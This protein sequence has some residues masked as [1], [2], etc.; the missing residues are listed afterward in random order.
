MSN[1]VLI[2]MP[3]PIHTPRLT[4][5]SKEFGD[6]AIT[7]AA[8]AETWE[9]LNRWMRWADNKNAFTP[10]LMEIRN[11]H[12][13]AAF[14]LRESIELIGL[15]TQTGKAVVWCGFHDIDWEARQCD[16]GYWVRKSAQRQGFAT[17]TA[18]AMLRYAFGALGMRRVGLT[19]SSGN[20]PTR[21][22]AQRLGF[23]LE[24]IQCKA[25]MLPGG[26]RT[27]RHCYAR[28]DVVGLPDLEVSWGEAKSS[29]QL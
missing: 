3:L 29:C 28:F 14:L 13:M 1:P 20:E 11:R 12:V 26:K 27:D 9:D 23:I 4:I 2:D 15:E 21:R 17:E 24:G 5:R 25:N 18:N 6:G 22:I 7:S 8:V 19:H 16:T 10:E